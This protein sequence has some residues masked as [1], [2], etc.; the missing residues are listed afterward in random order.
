M[1]P[2]GGGAR[3]TDTFYESKALGAP[4]VVAHSLED[5]A[6]GLQTYGVYG[7]G[8]LQTLSEYNASVAAGRAAQLRIPRRAK[9]NPVTTPPFYAL[10]V[11][12]AITFTLG[13]LR[14][15]A[16]ARVLDRAGQPIPGLYAAGVDAGGIHN[17]QYAG[18]LCLGLVFGRR[19]AHHALVRL[20]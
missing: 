13:G 2:G 6:D 19:A 12:T 5:L 9:A 3:P 20:P 1:R 7:P 8:V 11:T 18:G 16:D 4:A 14:T 10:G 17:E 15:D